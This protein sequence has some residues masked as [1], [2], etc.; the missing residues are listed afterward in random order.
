MYFCL[1]I[2]FQNNIKIHNSSHTSRYFP[3]KMS[4][5]FFFN[6][7]T[8]LKHFALLMR[9]FLFENAGMEEFVGLEIPGPTKT[10]F[11]IVSFI[12]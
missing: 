7:K 10:Q 5:S 9:Y 12:N 6:K 1:K 2:H 8:N 11:I 4:V 3:S